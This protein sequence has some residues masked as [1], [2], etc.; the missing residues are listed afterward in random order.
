M[1]RYFMLPGGRPLNDRVHHVEF[2]FG[3]DETNDHP[4]R[5]G[6][7]AV[8]HDGRD[9]NHCPWTFRDVLSHVESGTMIE[10]LL[11][12]TSN[13]LVVPTE[14]ELKVAATKRTHRPD[15]PMTNVEGGSW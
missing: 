5:V 12:Q 11:D 7:R 2:D 3:D 15:V 8:G 1:K 9:R 13:K 4:A 10:V 14:F 6:R